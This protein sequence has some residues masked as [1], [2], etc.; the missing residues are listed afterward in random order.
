[1]KRKLLLITCIC[2]TMAILLSAL[3][4]C[5]FSSE[6]YVG[7]DE[8]TR[9]G[10]VSEQQT[11]STTSTTQ[12]EQQTNNSNDDTKGENNNSA[13]I[14]S[15]THNV[16]EY[17]DEIKINISF[18]DFSGYTAYSAA[19]VDVKIVDST[20]T[21][22]YDKTL[23]KTESQSGVSITHDEI[24][25]G[26]TSTGTLYYKVYT[27]NTSFDEVSFELTKLP[28]T[29]NVTLPSTPKSVSYY[30]Y[31]GAI[32]STCKITE[33]SY[34]VGYGDS[35][36]IHFTGEKTYDKNG[37]NQSGYCYI[38]WK[39]YDSDGYVVD[40]GTCYTNSLRTGE[41]FKNAEAWA[42]DVIEEGKSYTLV[43]TDSN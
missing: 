19:S 20:N 38:A 1:M 22:I 15:M 26:S 21:V 18:K 11:N 13:N 10:S 14:K 2:L 4:A 40:T 17:S 31:S 37:S 34:T 33:I 36:C 8:E 39:L 6:N 24:T 25:V 7:Y 16:Y 35:L 12:N 28:W 9:K 3:S 23:K 29:V 43:I 5:D 32:Q 42:Y 27:D 30:S 41:K